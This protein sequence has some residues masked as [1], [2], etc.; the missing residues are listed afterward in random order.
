M[1]PVNGGLQAGVRIARSRAAFAI[2]ASRRS[3][4]S[5][6]RP[7]LSLVNFVFLVAPRGELSVLRGDSLVT[8]VSS[9]AQSQCLRGRAGH[10]RGGRV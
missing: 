6:Q 7:L 5:N 2:S 9:V 1:G 3:L 10:R 4:R 8:S